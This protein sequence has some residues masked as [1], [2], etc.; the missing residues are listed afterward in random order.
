[1]GYGQHFVYSAGT[2]NPITSEI[3][4]ATVNRKTRNEFV[5]EIEQWDWSHILWDA[6]HFSVKQSACYREGSAYIGQAGI[7]FP[8]AN[9]RDFADALEYV[10]ELHGGTI[11]FGQDG[12]VNFVALIPEIE[13]SALPLDF[14][15]GCTA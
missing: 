2:R 10:A 8:N 11:E 6:L 1:M 3:I 13:I 5:A 7:L 15:Y 9:A 12:E 14:S 4:M